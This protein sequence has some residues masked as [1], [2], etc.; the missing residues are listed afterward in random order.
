MSVESEILRIQHNI[1]RAYATVAE[2]GGQVPLQPTSA[3]LST[4]VASIPQAL[5]PPDNNPI[6]T[7]ISYMGLT[8]PKDY[9]ICD[10]AEHSISEYSELAELFKEQ[11][12]SANYFGGDGETTFAVPDMRNLFLRGYH[13]EAEEQLSG[14]VGAEQAATMHKAITVAPNGGLSYVAENILTNVDTESPQKNRTY[15]GGGS[16]DHYTTQSA[17]TSRPVNMAVLY[18]IKASK[19]TPAQNSYFTEETRIGTWVDG[20]PLYRKVCVFD[21]F[22]VAPTSESVTNYSSVTGVDGV[23]FLLSCWATGKYS[24]LGCDV[25]G[26]FFPCVVVDG[27]LK[28]AQTFSR[29]PIVLNGLSVT[30]EYTKNAENV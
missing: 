5:P 8:A 27:Q 25:G 23:D 9:L 15:Y 14:E 13:G 16:S 12:G 3:S 11:F 6:G 21:S 30:A 10:G 28:L 2:K 19:S 1:S 18:C 29:N 4:A 7:V 24:P 26:A 17:Y 22:S 20:K